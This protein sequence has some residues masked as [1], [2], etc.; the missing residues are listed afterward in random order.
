MKPAAAEFADPEQRKKTPRQ[1]IGSGILRPPNPRGLGPYR[2]DSCC[3]FKIYMLLCQY[4]FDIA[5]L[6]P[7]TGI[8]GVGIKSPQPRG[9]LGLWQLMVD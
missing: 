8:G 1:G 3:E 9:I 6:H 7:D 5:D 2:V 4:Q